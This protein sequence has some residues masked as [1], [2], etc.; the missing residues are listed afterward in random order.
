MNT[1]RIRL[2]DLPT[3]L[4]HWLLVALIAAA[5]ISGK[6]GGAAIDWHG[7]FGL[8]IVGL[9]TFRLVWGVIGSSYARFT[10]FF[11]TPSSVAAYLRGQWKG[12][13][14]NPLGAF[15]VFGLLALVALQ[16]GTGLFANDDIAFNGP[17][18]NLISKEL[19]DNLTGIHKLAIDLLIALIALHLT[20]I[21]FYTKVKKEQL[22]KPMITGWKDIQPGHGESARGGGLIAFII[23][24]AV[25][26]AIVYGASGVW[27]RTAQPPAAAAAPPAASW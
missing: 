10:S 4:F 1:T 19:S 13:G 11:P 12:V 23:A 3:R 8:A 25:A 21:A 26:L 15:S 17:L 5:I 24:L 7:R 20:A 22:I 18:F 9:I 27:S 16:V 6:I 2:W 14:H